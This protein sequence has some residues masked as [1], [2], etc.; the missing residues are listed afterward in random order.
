MGLKVKFNS[1]DL[2]LKRFVQVMGTVLNTT[3]SSL[4]DFT[5]LKIF[6]LQFDAR[7]IYLSKYL[8]EIF[9]LSLQRIY[10]IN[11]PTLLPVFIFRTSESI[12]SDEESY[13]FRTS[14]T[15]IDDEQIYLDKGATSEDINFQVIIP[16]AL[17]SLATD[18]LFIASIKKYSFADKIFE[19]III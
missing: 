14:E 4:S 11:D 17:S 6:E 15:I 1:V 19:I 10:I 16:S 12:T 5:T 13:L 7:T 3:R 8:N 18:P 9:D 2:I